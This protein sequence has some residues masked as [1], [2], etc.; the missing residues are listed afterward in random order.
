MEID[1]TIIGLIFIMF[2]PI[3]LIVNGTAYVIN[4]ESQ[5]FK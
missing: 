3:L 5:V 2:Y 4:K 1:K